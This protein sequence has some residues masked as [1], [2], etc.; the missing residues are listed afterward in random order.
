VLWAR[1]EVIPELQII[2]PEQYKRAK[3]IMKER[4]DKK[5]IPQYRLIQ[6]VNLLSPVRFTVGIAAQG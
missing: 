4:A 1:S 3:M 5:K 6:K 2:P